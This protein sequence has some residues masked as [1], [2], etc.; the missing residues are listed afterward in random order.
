MNNKGFIETIVLGGLAF[1]LMGFAVWSYDNTKN[2]PLAL[3]GGASV[4]IPSNNYVKV[5]DAT[6]GVQVK[7]LVSCDT[8]D[9]DADGKF[10]CGTDGG[11]GASLFTD[12]GT[13]VYPTNGETV[14]A[15]ALNATSTTAT[16][17]FNGGVSVLNLAQT[18]TAT[19]TFAKGID[20][21][22]G[23]FSIGGVCIAGT[24]TS[25]A[26]TVPTG[27]T[28]SGTPVTTSGT[29][30]IAYDTGY[31]GLLTASTTLW[32]DFYY[33]PSGRIT[34]G[35]GLS[36]STNTLNAEVQTSD[37]HDAV[38]LAGSLDY[39]TLSGQ[40]ITRGAI[41]LTTDVSGTLPV[42]NGGTGI[43]SLGT[44]V[45]TWF[46]TPTSAN[47]ASAIT[48]ETGT[49]ALV[50]GTSPTLVTPALGTPSALVLTNA[51]G[52]PLTSGV[53]GTL[54]VANGGT[55]ITTYT[56]GD[57]LYA[58]ASNVLSKLVVGSDGQVL[59]L[60]S[61][62]PS[63]GTDATGGGGGSGAFA[64]TT[65]SGIE[66]IYPAVSA[67]DFTL[68]GAGV[69]STSKFHF[70]ESASSLRLGTGT[71]VNS[72]SGI[73]NSYINSGFNFG[74]GT[75][76]PYAK[77]SVVGQ[78]VGEYF[79]ATSTTATSSLQATSITG[80]INILG[81]YFTNFTTYVRSIIAS[82]NL[83]VT[84]AWDFGGATSLEI[85]NG[86]N[87]T[88]DTAGEI[89]INTTTASSSLR[90]YD[91]ASEQ[92]LHPF[93]DKPTIHASS[94]LVY[95]GAYGASAT[96]TYMMWNPSRSVTLVDVYCKT[97]TG[98]AYY[99]IGNYTA[100]STVLCTTSGGHSTVDIAFNMRANVYEAVGTQTGNPS[101]ITVT[102]TFKWTAD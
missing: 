11:G 59:K 37:L 25:V 75:T 50:F 43:T 1:A 46:G 99:E 31:E 63:W 44:G 2:E 7:S 39:L 56:T 49:G 53:T 21:A 76:S 82:A 30:A 41:V 52:L 12:G 45:A 22:G 54:P 94:T 71:V 18:G 77:L 3:G 62:V 51:T 80:A 100:S 20:I 89:A 84:G 79:T 66:V 90:Y 40:A 69:I 33:T 47:L 88:V 17:T 91:G 9:T 34:A 26:Q 38:T 57:I 6:Y 78:V 95:D 13:F 8:I 55:N 97:N 60:A 101:R 24:V 29:L 28:V 92:T 68:G 35:T 32:G 102:P 65:D 5:F 96:T 48:N 36:W 70:D 98:T 27:F 87:P 23:C 73:A 86:T 10:V 14:N 4:W 72:F 15:P 61:G 16:S 83:V 42:A 85:V 19:S 58:S 81:E 64:T 74:I 67:S 93:F